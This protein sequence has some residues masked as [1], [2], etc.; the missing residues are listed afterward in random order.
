MGR[1][2]AGIG[3]IGLGFVVGGPAIAAIGAIGCLWAI[4][5]STRRL[6]KQPAI[7]QEIGFS[8]PK[9]TSPL[10]QSSGQFP[11]KILI[12]TSP[13]G[14]DAGQSPEMIPQ[15]QLVTETLPLGLDAGEFPEKLPN[16]GYFSDRFGVIEGGEIMLPLYN[17]E[18]EVFQG[19]V[20]WTPKTKEEM[21]KVLNEIDTQQKGRACYQYAEQLVNTTSPFL[22]AETGESAMAHRKE[23][24]Q[25]LKIKRFIIPIITEW[26]EVDVIA[27]K[28]VAKS[29]LGIE[30]TSDQ[31]ISLQELGKAFKKG[32]S[33]L[34][35]S[36]MHQ[37]FVEELLK[38][39]IEKIKSQK[40]STDGLL[41]QEINKKLEKYPE[42]TDLHTDPDLKSI[43][44][45]LLA[46]DNLDIVIEK[47]N[48]I[49]KV[50]KI[51]ELS[52]LEHEIEESGVIGFEGALD[53][54]ILRNR[55]KMPLL[56]ELYRIS[57]ND[58]LASKTVAIRYVENEMPCGEHII[59]PNS[60]LHI[61]SPARGPEVFSAGRRSCPGQ[62]V[63]ETV[64]KSIAIA[65]IR[66]LR[67]DRQVQ[68]DLENELNKAFQL[69]DT[70]S[71][72]KL[73]LQVGM[74]KI[75]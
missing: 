42:R 49:L 65:V 5:A 69:G 3:I 64:L 66:K 22:L 2:I 18:F 47:M 73:F 10:S 4:S 48:T 1:A 31:C 56:D 6:Q 70:D 45:L 51:D 17:D 13:L 14:L 62:F 58:A 9:E 26:N 75:V 21:A 46:V 29:W 15:L 37:K 74:P 25:F 44:L 8:S 34:V 20:Y 19:T 50:L 32:P 23:I 24:L 71:A 11:Q 39:Q 61:K 33:S 40:G 41:V 57:L 35:D 36:S 27:M 30:L 54:S 63:A 53:V 67:K 28:T 55:D 16:D 60:Y 68:T 52:N 7:E 12:E 38:E 59:P 43:I 72:M